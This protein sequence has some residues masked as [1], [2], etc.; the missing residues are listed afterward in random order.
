MVQPCMPIDLVCEFLT[1]PLGLSEIKPRLSWKISDSRPG[2][3]QKAYQIQAAK[4][5]DDLEKKPDLWKTDWVKSDNTLDVEW[6]GKQLRSKMKVFWRVRVKDMKG[7]ESPWSEIATFE[8]GLLKKSDWTGQWITDGSIRPAPSP[9]FRK[10]FALS[11]KPIKA[12]LNITARGLFEASLNGNKVGG[13]YFTPGWTEYSKRIHTLTYDVTDQLN[14]GDN[15]IGVTLGD[16]WFAGNMGW[17]RTRNIWGNNLSLLAELEMEL[18]DGTIEKIVSG[19]DW[20]FQYGSIRE[21]DIYNGETI[22]MREYKIGWDA[23]YFNDSSWSNALVAEKPLADIVCKP[24]RPV[25]KQEELPALILTEP[26]FGVHVF[27]LGQNMVGLVRVKI[28]GHYPGDEVVIRYA[29]MLKNDGMIYTENL[30]KAKCTDRVICNE[31]GEIVFEPKFTF[32]GFR[33]VEITGLRR[34][35]NLED[36]TGIVLH[37]EIPS[38]G[39]FECSEP[40]VNQLQSNI[41]WGQKGN[42]FEA[43]TDCPQRDERLG[44][45]GD[46]Q[47]FIGTAAFNRDVTSFFEKWCEDMEDAQFSDGRVPHVAPNPFRDDKGNSGGGGGQAAWADAVVICPWMIYLCYGDK[48]I[49]ENRYESMKKFVDWREKT[50][51]NYIHSEAVFGDWLAID[52][53]GEEC[54]GSP[55]PKDLIATAYFAR[56]TEIL[57]KTAEILGKATDVKKYSALLKKIKTAFNNEFVS[58]SGR[59]LGDTQCSYLLA[60]GFDLLD[61]EKRKAA[62]KNLVRTIEK[63]KGHLATGFVGTPLLAPVLTS[64]GR[65]DIAYQL[66]LKQT[67]PSWLYTVLQ[68][69]TTMW[70]RWNSYT[71]EKGFGNAS[72]NSFNHYA[73]GAIGEWMVSTVAGLKLD[74][75][76]PGYKHIIINPEPGNGITWAKAELVT[77]HGLVS[78][79]WKIEEGVMTCNVIVPPNTRATIILNGK[80]PIECKA[81]Q[82]EF[83]ETIQGN[84]S[85]GK[86]ESA[87]KIGKK[88]KLPKVNA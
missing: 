30:R 10:S 74:P 58:P 80:A 73:Y 43:P 60:L 14:Q 33:Y 78:S 9:Y 21:S 86:K 50:A 64:I 79:A 54:S 71:K 28:F 24:G 23:P 19:E 53:P 5:V 41:V 84:Q 69:A 44:W 57:T 52:I 61:T 7:K 68:G 29:E 35:P 72:M 48:R 88:K 17:A 27:D 63:W 20:K 37:T 81:G 83:K 4:S 40:L 82:F 15:V 1:N 3:I 59:I 51:K 67:Y 31:W 47:I 2:A 34:K 87:K 39:F 13:D 32:H 42:F 70:E 22:D 55:T 12:R 8:M 85:I 36:V 11:D 18:P 16:G 66:L 45:T 77:R 62:G 6:N 76:E 56:T 49:L 75:Q 38:T 25:K 65:T 46:A 26:Q